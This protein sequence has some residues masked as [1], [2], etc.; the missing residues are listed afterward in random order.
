MFPELQT[1]GVGFTY[2][3]VWK[4]LKQIYQRALT[5]WIF[6]NFSVKLNTSE[7]TLYFLSTVC[8]QG[9]F[10]ETV[11]KKPFFWK[12][13]F[14]K[15]MPQDGVKLHFPFFSSSRKFSIAN[16]FKIHIIR[17]KKRLHYDFLFFIIYLNA[18]NQIFHGHIVWYSRLG[19]ETWWP[20]SL[21]QWTQTWFYSPVMPSS[22][23]LHFGFKPCDYK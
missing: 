22:W 16:L 5:W 12:S 19:L 7:W 8:I 17:N 18:K 23:I 11:I 3:Y 15:E 14:V 4:V 1:F 10:Y 9:N 13:K 2:N 21:S 6:L 20:S